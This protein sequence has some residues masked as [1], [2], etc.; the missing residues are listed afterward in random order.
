MDDSKF[1][2][3][4]YSRNNINF[5]KE[6]VER[7]ETRGTQT[8]IDFRDIPPGSLYAEEIV[9]AI[10]HSICCVLIFTEDANASGYVINEMNSATNYNKP[11][12]PLRINKNLLPG[13]ALEFYIGKY[14]WI[15]YIGLESLDKLEQTIAQVGESKKAQTDIKYRSPVV[16]SG[17]N[18]HEIGYTAEKKVI[19]EMEI[20]YKTL[21]PTEYIVNEET[22]GTPPEWI[23]HTSSYPETSSM[24][25]VNDRIVGYYLLVL[26]NE[27]NYASII[28]GQKMVKA[29]MQEFY[30]FGGEF[31]CYVAIM[32]IIKTY[33]TQENY[34]L[35]IEEFFGK[36]TLFAKKGIK[37]K[38][39]AISVYSQL[40]EAMMRAL[41]FKVVGLNKA[42]GKIME[43][44]TEEIKSNKI[45]QTRFPEFC[46]IYED[47]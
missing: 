27:A 41:G 36:M 28:S 38:K 32:P 23:E 13:K 42:G 37:I 21:N 10:E 11:I 19:E 45:I 39:F 18:L 12:I 30:G 25:I 2:F 35:L 8:Y 15:D 14:N 40:L 9:K 44:S 47:M 22:E 6:I 24:L 31:F 26:M 34:L 3:I 16:I 33:E 20:D 43:L 1:V 5:V 4:S 17:E 7:L 46:K 29:D